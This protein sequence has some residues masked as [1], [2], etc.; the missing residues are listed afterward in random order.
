MRGDTSVHVMLEGLEVYAHHGVSPEERSTGGRYVLDIEFWLE[1]CPAC[2]SDE[3]G[4]T[5]D[6]AALAYRALAVVR[7]SSYRLL[8]RLATRVAEE[9]LAAFPVDR[10]RVRATKPAPPLDV[11]L[12]RASVT[13]E[14][15]RADAE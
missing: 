4:D 8:E 7:E 10:V 5:V 12:A 2:L 15:R 3:L 11:H 14:L 1:H 6:Y 9:I 13:V